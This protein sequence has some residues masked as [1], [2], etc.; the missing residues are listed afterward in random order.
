MTVAMT[1]GIVRARVSAT[2]ETSPSSLLIMSPVWKTS[3]PSQRLSMILVKY[4]CLSA[5]RRLTSVFVSSLL[6]MIEKMI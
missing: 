6:M 3:L 4:L 2:F 5:L 1:A